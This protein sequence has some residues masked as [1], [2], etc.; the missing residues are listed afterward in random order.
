MVIQMVVQNWLRK[1]LVKTKRVTRTQVLTF[2]NLPVRYYLD[3]R[4]LRP[5]PS[6]MVLE[7]S[8]LD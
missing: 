3:Y 4:H 6:M 2:F 8:S 1:E 7:V 5:L